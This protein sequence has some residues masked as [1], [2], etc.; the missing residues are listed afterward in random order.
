MGRDQ[1]GGPVGLG[2]RAP[3]TGARGERRRGAA[4]HAS[5]HAD[6]TSAT[7]PALPATR[8]HG[9]ASPTFAGATAALASGTSGQW[10][11]ASGP[12]G[13]HPAV[14]LALPAL[15]RE[16][17]V[18]ARW[19]D[20]T[21][22]LRLLARS[23]MDLAR[24]ALGSWVGSAPV[25]HCGLRPLAIW[26]GLAVSA[27]LPRPRLGTIL[28]LP[29]LALSASVRERESRCA[30]PASGRWAAGR[31]SRSPGASPPGGSRRSPRRNHGS[32]KKCPWR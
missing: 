6:A 19:S 29:P 24:R 31:R 12:V 25:L 3:C 30:A 10:R 22:A 18:P 23:G 4:H 8:E 20:G 26:L 1:S 32:W 27:R 14:R 9:A 11:A 5:T 17:R 13:L 2:R 15:R 28:A 16:L 7:E 21:V